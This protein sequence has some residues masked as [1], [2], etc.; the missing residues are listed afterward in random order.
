M[1]RRETKYKCPSSCSLKTYTKVLENWSELYYCHKTASENGE[2]RT[3]LLP[4]GIRIWLNID[5][6]HIW[7]AFKGGHYHVIKL[8]NLGKLNCSGSS[9]SMLC[10]QKVVATNLMLIGVPNLGSWKRNFSNKQFANWG[11]TASGGNWKC[12]PWRERGGHFL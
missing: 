7:P 9:Y 10:Q 2:I 12:T 1:N 6:D 8:C 5:S 4:D 11:K 3:F